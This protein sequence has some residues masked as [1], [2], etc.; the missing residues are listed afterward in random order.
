MH[1]VLTF[2]Y[3]YSVSEIINYFFR[4]TKPIVVE[5]IEINDYF[6]WKNEK[7]ITQY[8]YRAS[9]LNTS[10]EW[11]KSVLIIDFEQVP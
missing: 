7:H 11:M 3:T 6:F 5:I 8:K 4:D 9:R 10:S 2:Y 1:V